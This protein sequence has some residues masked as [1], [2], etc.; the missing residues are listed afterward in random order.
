MSY[1]VTPSDP[2][3]TSDDFTSLLEKGVATAM[4]AQGVATQTAYDAFRNGLTAAQSVTVVQ[5]ILDC[6]KCSAP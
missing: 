3:W 2:A 5:R 1:R 4:K 6:V